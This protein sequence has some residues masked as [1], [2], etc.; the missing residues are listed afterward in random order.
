MYLTAQFLRL[1]LISIFYKA[2][3]LQ[4]TYVVCFGADEIY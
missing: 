1:L 3:R 2:Q 4:G